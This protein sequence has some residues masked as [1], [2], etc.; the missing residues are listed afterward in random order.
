MHNT[1]FS[2]KFAAER[3]EKYREIMASSVDTQH[4]KRFPQT[5]DYILIIINF[6]TITSK[7]KP[8]FLY[9]CLTSVSR[10]C[11]FTA[12]AG[13]E[14]KA[15]PVLSTW[16]LRSCTSLL[17]YYA[18]VAVYFSLI[19]SL[20]FISWLPVSEAWHVFKWIVYKS[21]CFYTWSSGLPIY[22]VSSF[23]IIFQK[24]EDS[25]PAFFLPSKLNWLHFVFI[26][27]IYCVNC[28]CL[29]TTCDF[30]LPKKKERKKPW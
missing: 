23:S 1:L 16:S 5:E 3:K 6:R 18:G 12:P 7:K 21:F 4:S 19:T 11:A 2:T 25:I 20:N 28:P 14:K 8:W 13:Q 9:R 24:L 10:N 30:I 29:Y 26:H 27:N 17:Y 22:G 15:E